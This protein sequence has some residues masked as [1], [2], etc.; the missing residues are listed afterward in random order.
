[1]P[2]AENAPVRV[3]LPRP[4]DPVGDNAMDEGVVIDR[5]RLVAW[6]EVEDAAAAAPEGAAAAEHLAAA[7]AVVLLRRS[8]VDAVVCGN[9]VMAIG[10]PDAATRVFGRRAR[11]SGRDWPGRHRHAVWECHDLTTLA[12]DHVRFIETIVGLIERDRAEEGEP[13]VATLD[14]TVRWGSTC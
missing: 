6:A 8:K 9:D 14:C 3:P 7:V 12:P 5:K 2:L 10:V 4:A 1:M 11:R 13:S